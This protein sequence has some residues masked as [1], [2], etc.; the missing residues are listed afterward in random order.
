VREFPYNC[1]GALYGCRSDIKIMIG[2]AFLISAD[3]AVTAAPLQ[4]YFKRFHSVIFYPGVSGELKGAEQF[5]VVDSRL[6]KKFT[7]CDE[8]ENDYALLKLNRIVERPAYIQLG[9]EY[10]QQE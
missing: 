5:E 7:A 2:T 9:L 6:P 1:V 3:L 10:V 8:L 4:E